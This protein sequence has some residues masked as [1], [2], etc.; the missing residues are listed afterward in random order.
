MAIKII[1]SK[2]YAFSKQHKWLLFL[3][4]VILLAII[5]GVNYNIE[6]EVKSS[7]EDIEAYA[8]YYEIRNHCFR[9]EQ[10]Y[11]IVSYKLVEKPNVGKKDSSTW[12]Q[13]FGK[14]NY[15][16]VAT[17]K[18]WFIIQYKGDKTGIFAYRIEPYAV[19]LYSKDSDS[20]ASDFRK[21]YDFIHEGYEVGDFDCSPITMKTKYHYFERRD[22]SLSAETQWYDHYS[23]KMF[24]TK[25]PFALFQIREDS[26]KIEQDLYT[27]IIFSILLETLLFALIWY[28]LKKLKGKSFPL[29]KNLKDMAL[30]MKHTILS[31]SETS[32]NAVTD[33]EYEF[34]LHKINPINFMNPYDAEKVKVANDLYSAL[35]KSRDNETIIHL[36]KEKAK[37]ELNINI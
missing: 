11:A 27:Y 6:E 1:A 32:D 8:S 36:I 9:S 7:K 15:Y 13:L 21:L 28:L 24:F 20:P 34:L 17:N 4:G 18:P 22:V 12:E 29:F 5:V 2:V 30:N 35:L 16:Y 14:T 23:D 19:A 31:K 10:S 25:Q 37:A 26:S 33:A 3:Y